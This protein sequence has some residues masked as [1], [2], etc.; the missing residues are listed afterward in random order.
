DEPP[1][2][3]PAVPIMDVSAASVMDGDRRV[4][5]APPVDAE[6]QEDPD[7]V[8]EM[9]VPGGGLEAEMLVGLELA[10]HRAEQADQ[11]E[12]RSDEDVEAVEARR[13]EEGRRVDVV[14]EA[15]RGVRI[16]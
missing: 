15:E 5:G 4:A 8:D 1:G 9:P 2:I 7:D 14:T 16:L 13:H 10:L 3:A 12:G 11:Q 6:E